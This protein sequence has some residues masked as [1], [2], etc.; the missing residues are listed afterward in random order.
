MQKMAEYLFESRGDAVGRD[1]GESTN[2]MGHSPLIL[3]HKNA[4]RR[5]GHARMCYFSDATR[6]TYLIYSA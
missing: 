6:P 2:Q 1:I 3:A 5:G 4:S